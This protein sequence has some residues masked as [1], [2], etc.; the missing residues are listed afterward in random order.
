MTTYLFKTEP[1]EFSWNDLV[2]EKMT[3]WTGV[4][5]NTA[6]MNLRACKHG[7]EVF[8][9]HT[10]NERRIVGLARITSSPYPDPANS[11]LN[12]KGEPRFAVVDVKAIAPAKTPVTLAQLKE[13]ER[14]DDFALIRQSRLSVMRVPAKLD[15]II[16]K[17]AGF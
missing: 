4:T 9:Y 15:A 13:D 3:P 11:G 5:N 10:G 14:F 7:D 16:R 12:A 6:L 8:I 2:K 17:M 1:D